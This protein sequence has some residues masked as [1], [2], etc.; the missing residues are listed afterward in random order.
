M[1]ENVLSIFLSDLGVVTLVNASNDN[2]SNLHYIL[3]HPN[4]RDLP[5]I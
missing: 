1:Q 3:L 5:F 4:R 2:D